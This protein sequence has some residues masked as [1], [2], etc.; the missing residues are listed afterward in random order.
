MQEDVI[1]QAEEGQRCIYQASGEIYLVRQAQSS[2]AMTVRHRLL[3][4]KQK[5]LASHT[6]D[7]LHEITKHR[8][9]YSMEEPKQWQRL[10]ALGE[11]ALERSVRQHQICVTISLTY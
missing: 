9:E 8:I 5:V 7:A 11:M 2:A 10:G 1:S 3:N 4:L 6:A